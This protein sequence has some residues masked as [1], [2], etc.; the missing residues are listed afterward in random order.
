MTWL[1][2]FNVKLIQKMNHRHLGGNGSMKYYF[3]RIHILLLICLSACAPLSDKAP[4]V[5]VA[6]INS[7]TRMPSATATQP[8]KATPTPTR[9]P[10]STEEPEPTIDMPPGLLML[11][12]N[13]NSKQ[14]DGRSPDREWFWGVEYLPGINRYDYSE[15]KVVLQTRFVNRMATRSFT[16][17]YSPYTKGNTEVYYSPLF[18][19]KSGPY[20]YLTPDFCCWDAPGTYFYSGFKLVRLNLETGKLSTIV[21][22]SLP[23]TGWFKM[24]D[25]SVSDD[26]SKVLMTEMYKKGISVIQINNGEKS[27]YTLPKDI[28]QAG[29]GVWS[30]DEKKVAFYGCLV[31][32]DSCSHF[33][34]LLLDTKTGQLRKLVEDV[35][36]IVNTKEVEDPFIFGVTKLEWLDEKSIKLKIEEKLKYRIDILTGKVMQ[37]PAIG[38]P[39]N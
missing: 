20:V 10:V 5:T 35:T 18:W 13:R 9:L 2:Y 19:P 37:M 1:N 31:N 8:L 34:I 22:G 3:I 7:S 26:G 11:E 32:P 28:E 23:A 39:S 21:D 6:Q 14:I 27:Y 29:R 12:S 25:F 30:A 38:Q 15:D 17:Q 4:T 36:Q 33:G 16:I 24:Y